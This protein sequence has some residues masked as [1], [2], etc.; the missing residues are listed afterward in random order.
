[1]PVLLILEE[2]SRRKKG[3]AKVREISVAR[4]LRLV[5][6]ATLHGTAGNLRRQR[7]GAPSIDKEAI[8]LAFIFQQVPKRLNSDRARHRNNRQ[9]T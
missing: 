2:R 1:V 5:T 7:L 4:V 9:V 6:Q 8:P 3:N